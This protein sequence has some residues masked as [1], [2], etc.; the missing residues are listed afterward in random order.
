MSISNGSYA[1]ATSV[2]EGYLALPRTFLA[3]DDF[4]NN[5]GSVNDFC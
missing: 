2:S 5:N 4:E 3:V 1:D